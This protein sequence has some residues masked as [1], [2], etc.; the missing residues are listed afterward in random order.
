[1]QSS[2]LTSLSLE[3]RK[4]A[5]SAWVPAHLITP[6]SAPSCLLPAEGEDSAAATPAA[7]TAAPPPREGVRMAQDDLGAP[8][9]PAHMAYR[10]AL[11]LEV[12]GA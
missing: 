3:M 4:E 2:S 7:A 10:A 11:E 1:M 5:A 12:Q 9:V 8:R 6:P